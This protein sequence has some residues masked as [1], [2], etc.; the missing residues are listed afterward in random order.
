MRRAGEALVRSGVQKVTFIGSP[1][2]GKKVMA[3]AADSLTPVVLELGGKDP[4]VLCDD[5]DLSQ[6]RAG[7]RCSTNW[8]RRAACHCYGAGRHSTSKGADRAQRLVVGRGDRATVV[9][10]RDARLFSKL[11]PK[12]RWPGAAHCPDQHLR[13]GRRRALTPSA[14]I[15]PGSVRTKSNAHTVPPRDIDVRAL[16]LGSRTGAAAARTDRDLPW[17][18]R[19][20]WAR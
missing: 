17:K 12:L 20:T 5:A 16:S 2:V 14:L 7:A 4:M 15:A 19:W 11:W 1:G 3:T 8:E 9:Q 10:R 13:P 18:T 6:V